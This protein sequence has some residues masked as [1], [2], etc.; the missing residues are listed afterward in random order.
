MRPPFLFVATRAR[1]E[2]LAVRGYVTLS[3][4]LRWDVVRGITSITRV[5]IEWGWGYMWQAGSR[6]GRGGVALCCI[7]C[8]VVLLGVP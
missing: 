7:C 6:R 5:W 4:V 8:F 3:H 1:D 2:S